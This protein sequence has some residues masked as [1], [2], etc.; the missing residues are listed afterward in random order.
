MFDKVFY[1]EGY[2]SN[3][4]PHAAIL[5]K[6]FSLS[7]LPDKADL[8][9][10]PSQLSSFQWKCWQDPNPLPSAWL[11][12][13]SSPFTSPFKISVLQTPPSYIYSIRQLINLESL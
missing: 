7:T 8:L 9:H 2:V 3:G 6:L 10:L 5:E 11:I 12:T 13:T 1:A 4:I